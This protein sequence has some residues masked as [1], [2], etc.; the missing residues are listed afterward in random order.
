MKYALKLGFE[1]KTN[2]APVERPETMAAVKHGY[3]KIQCK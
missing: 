3:M 2:I 1:L